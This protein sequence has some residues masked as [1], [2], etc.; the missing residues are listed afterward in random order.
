MSF[1]PFENLPDQLKEALKEMMKKIE[2]LDPNELSKM[3]SQAF[4]PESM[5]RIKEMMSDSDSFNFGINLDPESIKQF[6]KM[7]QNLMNQ[8][9][10]HETNPASPDIEEPY[11][12]I[13]SN[14]DTDGEIIVELPGITDVRA[15]NWIDT[16]EG[17]VLEAKT[18]DLI[19]RVTIP[20]TDPIK[21][22][23]SFAEI[24][25]GVLILPYK[26]ISREM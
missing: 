15:V 16:A 12:E 14:N 22:Q 23:A 3:M 18:T 1:D 17:L 19:Y 9:V 20:I 7:F 25:N 26:K 11:F 13:I 10:N 6:E 4:N 5:E 24:K 8:S 21:I 2:S